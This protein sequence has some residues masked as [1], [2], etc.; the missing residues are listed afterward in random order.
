MDKDKGWFYVFLFFA[1]ITLMSC[2]IWAVNNEYFTDYHLETCLIHSVRPECLKFPCV[3]TDVTFSL[4]GKNESYRASVS[5][6]NG[7]IKNEIP[8]FA[9]HTYSC[10]HQIYNNHNWYNKGIIILPNNNHTIV[11]RIHKE[12]T[13]FIMLSIIYVI[14][15]IIR[16]GLP[17]LL[18]RII[19]REKYIEINL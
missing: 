6:D 4:L 12:R 9:N 11:I 14:L 18:R 13:V 5:V 8:L 19:G 15:G 1:C 16:Y 17:L 10:R 3:Y 7:L 2:F